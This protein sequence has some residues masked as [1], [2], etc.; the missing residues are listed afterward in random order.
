[1]TLGDRHPLRI[2]PPLTYQEFK[3]VRYAPFSYFNLHGIEDGPNWYG[4]RDALFPATY[5]LFPVAL[6]PEDLRPE[7][8]AGAIVFSEACYGANI[9][10]KNS[11]TSLALKFLAA[12]ARAVIGS[13]KV[14][15]GTVAPPLIG[16]DLLARYFWKGLL[17]HLTI[18][19]ALK[20]AKVSLAREMQERQGYLDSEDQKTLLSFVLYGDPALPGLPDGNIELVSKALC[21]PLV[22]QRQ[23][24]DQKNLLSESLVAAVKGRIEASLP[25]L[26]EARVQ[27]VP[28]ILSESEP[29][30][31]RAKSRGSRRPV[32]RWAF[33]LEKDFP[34]EGDGAHRQVVTVTVDEHGAILKAVMSK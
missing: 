19:E 15:Y 2:S 30:M 1:Q 10:G 9:L 17:A 20:Y 13:T 16:A 11:D 23:A 31:S 4:Q 12:R 28:V 27:A 33:T 8:Y 21:P 6:R 18:G 29:E 3:Q 26:A 7:D 32:A 25:Y 5:E 14:S 34:V 24:R 22:Y